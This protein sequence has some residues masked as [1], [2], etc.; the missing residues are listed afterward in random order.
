MPKSSPYTNECSIVIRVR[1][2][3]VYWMVEEV[4]ADGD[5]AIVLGRWKTSLRCQHH[6]VIRVCVRHAP[7]MGLN[8][9]T[10]DVYASS[11]YRMHGVC[12]IAVA[13]GWRTTASQST[14]ESPQ[15]GRCPPLPLYCAH[16]GGG[17]PGWQTSTRPTTAPPRPA[18]P[19]WLTACRVCRLVEM[20]HV[21]CGGVCKQMPY[22]IKPG[23]ATGNVHLHSKDHSHP[24]VHTTLGG[25]GLCPAKASAS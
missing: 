21:V 4:L 24:T 22:G 25:S 10:A 1:C 13:T 16:G 12:S 20:T 3:H 5:Q 9:P 11:S 19:P 15:S 17:S 18:A 7:G 14:L 8:R 2:C 6:L 23:N